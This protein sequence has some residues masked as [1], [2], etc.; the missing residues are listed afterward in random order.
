MDHINN[1]L[2]S[3][4]SSCK[5]QQCLLLIRLSHRRRKTNQVQVCQKPLKKLELTKQCIES[6]SEQ[7]K[8][9]IFSYGIIAHISNLKP[10]NKLK[11]IRLLTFSL[12]ST[13]QICFSDGSRVFWKI[14]R[15]E[16]QVEHEK[17][18]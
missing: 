10:I 8:G 16:E 1:A 5:K 14:S 13:F 7:I 17:R 2:D 12:D 9:K 4:T 3:D 6:L 18:L 11:N 15:G